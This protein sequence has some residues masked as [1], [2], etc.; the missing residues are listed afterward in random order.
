MKV[1]LIAVPVIL[2]AIII[3]AWHEIECA[4]DESDIDD[5]DPDYFPYE[6]PCKS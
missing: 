3:Y 2:I 6:I 5:I 4:I 1:L